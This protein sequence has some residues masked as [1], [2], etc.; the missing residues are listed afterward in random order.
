ML[1]A[2]TWSTGTGP[3]PH[4]SRIKHKQ[5]PVDVACECDKVVGKRERLVRSTETGGSY[6]RTIKHARI[7]SNHAI[8]ILFSEMIVRELDRIATDGNVT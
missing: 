8:A 5:V 1:R 6:D 3:L 7:G 4:C 2:N